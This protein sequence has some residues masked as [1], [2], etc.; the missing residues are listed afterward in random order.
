[1]SWEMLPCDLQ[2]HI[3]K[4]RNEMRNKASKK[5]QTAWSKHIYPEIFAKDYVLMIHIDQYNEI[6]VSLKSTEIILKFCLE[7]ISG[8]YY[9]KF[10]KIIADKLKKSL[11]IYKYSEDEWLTQEAINYRKIKL[12]YLKLLKE[13]NFK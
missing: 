11:D 7:I 5:I 9:V 2:V 12:Q 13:F 8:K 3:L 10:W 1:M 6:M 4:L